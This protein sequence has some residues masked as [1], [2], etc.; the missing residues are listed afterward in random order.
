[1]F[2]GTGAQACQIEKVIKDG[3]SGHVKLLP[4]QPREMLGATL[5]ACDV[6]L[7]TLQEGLSGLAVPS[8]L[9]GILAAGKPTIV[10]GPKDCE[11]AR[12]VREK[13]CGMVVPPGHAGALA[14]VLRELKQDSQLKERLGIAARKAFEQSFDLSVISRQWS[15][16][17]SDL[18]EERDQ[19]REGWR[20]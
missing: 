16:L 7:V 20:C 18:G 12:V 11:A 13:R 14:T 1:L 2:I 17:L 10:I 19:Q 5:T 6:G 4:F 15:D 9:Y 3:G 8:K